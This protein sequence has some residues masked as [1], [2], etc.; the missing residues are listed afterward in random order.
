M[1]PRWSYLLPVVLLVL[2]L[3]LTACGGKKKTAATATPTT[4]PTAAATATTAATATQSV[5]ATA[6][7]TAA[8]TATEAAT[9][10]ATATESATAAVTTA[11]S[12]EGT[13]EGTEV[14]GA[15][16]TSVTGDPVQGKALF[17]SEGCS[18]CHSVDTDQTI[19]GPSLMGIGSEAAEGE[20]DGHPALDYLHQ[21][22]VDPGAVI[23]EGFQNLMPSFKD[24]LTEAQIQDLIA[25][26]LTLK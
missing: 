13:S 16:L 7:P 9:T 19:V 25:Y 4:P 18:T 23:V 3:S 5:T 2:G 11:E 8:A 14:P 21:S 1:K 26:L 6:K 20:I 22:I 17:T 12:V 24:K 10:A 15:T